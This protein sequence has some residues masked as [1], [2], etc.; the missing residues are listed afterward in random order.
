MSEAISIATGTGDVLAFTGATRLHGYSVRE[1]A[2]T[3]AVATVIL[4]D[5]TSVA[6]TP[7]AYIELA[8]N[9]SDAARIPTVDISAGIFVDRVAGETELVL[10][11]D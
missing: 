7:V 3:G 9:A 11:V 2:T 8:A 4:R 1:S 10:Y 6:G 5:G